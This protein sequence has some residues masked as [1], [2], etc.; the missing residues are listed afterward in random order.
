MENIW[1]FYEVIDHILSWARVG[2]V[3][4]FKVSSSTSRNPHFWKIF[5]NFYVNFNLSYLLQFLSKLNKVTN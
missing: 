5:Y 2:V 3:L 4:T 1:Y